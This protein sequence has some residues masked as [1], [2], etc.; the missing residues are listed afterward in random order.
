MKKNLNCAI[1]TI[2]LLVLSLLPYAA[3][4]TPVEDAAEFAAELFT[5]DFDEMRER[6]LIRFL[7]P[8]SKTDYQIVVGVPQG[9]QADLIAE[10]EKQLEEKRDPGEPPIK[11]VKLPVRFDQLIPALIN[12][13]GDIAAASL[14]LTSERE[15]LVDFVTPRGR[16]VDEL[17]VTSSDYKT[18]ASIEE[19][20]GQSVYVLAGSSYI[21]HLKAL[22]LR[23]SEAGLEEIDIIEADPNLASEDI[24]ELVNAGVVK[25]T[26]VDDYRARLWAQV[27]PNIVVHEQIKVH[28]GGWIGWAIRKNSPEL[29]QVLTEFGQKVKRGSL[30]GNILFKRHYENTKWISNPLDTAN[31]EKLEQLVT[32]FKKYGSQYGF[33]YL[34]L[35]AQAYQESGLDHS[36]K[37]AAGAIGIMQL[38]PTT[39]K[40]PNVDIEDISSLENNI[41]AGA[42]YM[43]FLRDRYFSDRE[44]SEEDR[45]AF[46]WAA[47]NAGPARV[48]QLR[49]QA[50]EE[51]L[52]PNQ[53]FHN[54]EYIALEKVGIEPVRYVS[55]I[56]KYYIAYR[57]LTDMEEEGS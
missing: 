26:V 3:A 20:A 49:E 8:R 2:S 55:N 24:L 41:H 12:G 21:T 19:L 44:L 52:D 57:L 14:T 39:A 30:L 42:K 46:T 29:F 18:L 50:N 4:Q 17:V 28:E 9:L 56:Y 25:A 35:A 11:I 36:A 34:A 31:R 54:V 10:Y 7:V 53:W 43:A 1:A 33:D 40:D 38:L 48:R 16:P 5:G 22:N 32:L 13:V 15:E 45:F 23:L 51:G 47:Y 27:L 37:S 6:R